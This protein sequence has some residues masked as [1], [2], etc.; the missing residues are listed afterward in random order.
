MCHASNAYMPIALNL[1]I[2]IQ[3]QPMLFI[4]HDYSI[5]ECTEPDPDSGYV[6][7]ECFLLVDGILKLR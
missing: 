2:L 6:C 5:L 1:L 7:V 4:V 3:Y